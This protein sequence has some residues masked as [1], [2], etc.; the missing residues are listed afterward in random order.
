MADRHPTRLF[1]TPRGKAW[2]TGNAQEA[3]ARLVNQPGIERYTLHGLRKTGPSALKML[4]FENRAIRSLTGHTSDKNLELYLD[5]VQHLPLAKAAQE[6]L[7]DVFGS[8]IAEAEARANARRFNG[9]TG[10]AARAAKTVNKL[11]TGKQT[12]GGEGPET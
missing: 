1:V 11:K 3:L 4:G 5:G 10:R 7:E 8:V 12:S 9:V 2:T 6:A